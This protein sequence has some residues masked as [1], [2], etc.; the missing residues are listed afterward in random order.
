MGPALATS[1]AAMFNA[2][3]LGGV[4]ARRGQLRLDA[5]F[6]LRVPRMLA[7]A[8]VMAAVLAGAQHALFGIAVPHGAL[9]LASLGAL[10]A[11]GLAAYIGCGHALGAYDLRD[12]PRMLRRRALPR[13]G[14]SAITPPPASLS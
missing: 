14:R 13:A 10:I 8:L 3:G 1:L 11:T 5:Q 2:A 6:R 9:R 7:A 4:L 12:V